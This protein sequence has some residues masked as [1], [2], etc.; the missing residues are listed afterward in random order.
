[1]EDGADIYVRVEDGAEH[2]LPGLA[3]RL[4]RL[5][6]CPALRLKRQFHC[7]LIRQWTASLLLKKVKSLAPGESTDLLQPFDRHKGGERLALSLDD[8]F[9][10]TE[11]NTVE[12]VADSLSDI[13]SG[14]F[15]L[16]GANSCN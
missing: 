3:P 7:L 8:K 2:R 14:Y 6:T 9:I 4:S 1:M 11:G 10:M 16:H 12:Q 15:L 13:D 5:S